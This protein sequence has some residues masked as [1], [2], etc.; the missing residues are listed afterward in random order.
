MKLVYTILILLMSM[1]S[2]QSQEKM[3]RKDAKKLKVA[4]IY[5]NMEEPL[6]ARPH[7]RDI[8]ER[9]KDHAEVNFGLGRSFLHGTGYLE[10]SEDHLI[11]A[12]SNGQEEAS[13]Y[14]AINYLK[15]EKLKKAQHYLDIYSSRIREKTYEQIESLSQ[16]IERAIDAYG[17]QK[18]AEVSLLGKEINSPFSDYVPVIT[19]DG[20]VMF[21]TSKRLDSSASNLGILEDGDEDIY[22]AEMKDDQWKT[23]A[24]IEG[25]LNSDTH[26]AMVCLLNHGSKIVIYRTRE[27]MT[28]GDL[29]ISDYVDE[30]WTAPSQ[31]N[32][33]INSEYTESSA[34]ISE[35]NDLIY[36]SSNRPGGYGGKDIY[37]LVKFQNGEWSL[38]QNLGPTIN[39]PQDEDGPFYHT[40]SNKLY[41]MSK[42]HSGIG[43][44]DI[45]YSEQDADGVWQKIHNLGRPVNSTCDDIY[46]AFDDNGKTAYFSSDRINGYGEQDIYKVEFPVLDS[47]QV[48]RAIITHKKK[49]VQAKVTLIDEYS[50][51]VKGVYN[52][53]VINGN[54]VMVFEPGKHYQVVIEADGYQP[55]VEHLVT[56]HSKSSIPKSLKYELIK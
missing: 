36:F 14:L 16:T 47:F 55:V 44:F 31:F 13:Y 1:T 15:Q 51:D 25:E 53:N 43:G 42:G 3:K 27:N 49:P 32:D 30:N 20:S 26:D 35:G 37:R 33:Q 11:K 10:E 6:L 46:I 12:L 7:L 21:F 22:M 2:G 52:S 48:V 9:H 34:W 19:A 39:S 54:L 41:F 8:Y 4:Q 5:L 56:E 23:A 24:S 50:K 45:F 29:L 28:G 17:R 38:P 18:M 40:K